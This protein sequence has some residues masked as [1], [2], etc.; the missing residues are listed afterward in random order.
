VLK[1]VNNN[2]KASTQTQ[3]VVTEEY[4]GLK[5]PFFKERR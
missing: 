4:A 2:E 1:E 3:E 5:I